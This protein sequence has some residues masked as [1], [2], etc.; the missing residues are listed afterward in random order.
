MKIQLFFFEQTAKIADL[1]RGMEERKAAVFVST[2]SEVLIFVSS[3]VKAD[4]VVESFL[5]GSAFD[6]LFFHAR[7][8][9]EKPISRKIFLHKKWIFSGS[10]QK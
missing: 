1:F 5:S 7:R 3:E 6:K 9:P 2:K 8:I 4:W 10:R